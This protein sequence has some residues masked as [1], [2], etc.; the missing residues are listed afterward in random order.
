MIKEL[1]SKLTGNI[2]EVQ[3]FSATFNCRKFL[4]YGVGRAYILKVHP[5]FKEDKQLSEDLDKIMEYIKVNYDMELVI[6][7]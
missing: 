4:K 7:Q 3:L 5:K 1:I 6:K 2:P